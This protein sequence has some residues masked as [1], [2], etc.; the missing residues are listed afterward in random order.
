MTLTATYDDKQLLALIAGGDQ[1][2]FRIFFDRYK[3]RFYGVVI[4][5]TRSDLLAEEIVQ[6]VFMHIW[7]NRSLLTDIKEPSSYF[8]TAVYRRIYS[9]YKK[10]ALHRTLL[11]AVADVGMFDNQTDETILAREA[12]KK[13]AQAIAALPPQ[14]QVV[15]R[16][17]RQEGLSRQ[18]IAQQLNLSPNTVK[19]H[20]AAALKSIRAFLDQSALTGFYLFWLFKDKF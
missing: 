8:F 15:L 5:M 9:Y 16:L 2:A 14:Q 7:K 1:N 18:E 17:S 3:D 10:Q 13:I 11:Q 19:N 12:E 4:K 6:E 20:M